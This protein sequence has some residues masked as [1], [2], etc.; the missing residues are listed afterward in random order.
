M[1]PDLSFRGGT[2][3]VGTAYDLMRELI[4]TAGL[5]EPL[6]FEGLPGARR[7]VNKVGDD[8]EE[9]L[10]LRWADSGGKDSGNPKDGSVQRMRQLVRHVRENN[11]PTAVS[12]LALSGND[13]IAAGF[14]PGPQMGEILRWLTDQV[15][16]DP[17][18][19]EKGS[20]LGLAHSREWGSPGVSRT[21]NILDPVSDAL[22][23][24]A[25]D[26]ADR[27][28]PDVKDSVRKFAIRKIHG[29]L[30]KA[31]W[32]D[33]DKLDYV[34]L[35]LTGS[36]TTYQWGET[37]DFDVSV[38]VKTENLPE[39]V[40]A[41]L[42]GIMIEACDGVVVPGTTHPLQCF[43]VD[44]ERYTTDDLYRPGLRSAYDLKDKRWLVYPER[45]R[46]QDVHKS[47]PGTIAYARTVEDK[48]R[49]MLRYGNDDALRLYWHFIHKQ[50]M[51]DMAKGKGDY[52]DSN[53][54]YKWL[55]NA[56]LLPQ[57][58]EA[59]GTYIAT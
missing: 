59:L 45:H 18:L 31:G 33:P 1:R 47:Y 55:V 3:V 48:V 42:I 56:G 12:Q 34:D 37:S 11:Q 4:E 16:E 41:D 24:D 49:M 50:R 23:P 30:R 19:N 38:W 7:F 35:I 36:L 17:S 9:L 22:D 53:I 46:A 14:K 43:V 8:A 6:P 39:W 2:R 15:I 29:A 40:R 13:L 57:I 58:A 44:T 20:L 27:W 25:F 10:T 52:A 28:D 54:V 51:R 26:H 21:A 32:P 5:P